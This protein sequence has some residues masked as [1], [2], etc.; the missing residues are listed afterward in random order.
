MASLESNTEA[1]AAFMLAPAQAVGG[2]L[3]GIPFRR[4]ET[5][6]PSALDCIIGRAMFGANLLEGA[7]GCRLGSLTLTYASASASPAQ[8][9]KVSSAMEKCLYHSTIPIPS[10]GIALPEIGGLSVEPESQ[11]ERE[12]GQKQRKRTFTI[13]IIAKLR[14]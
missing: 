4:W 3:F 11:L 12:D 9:D 2:D 6:D 10:I 5:T 7:S 14:D 8:A 1:F 13:P